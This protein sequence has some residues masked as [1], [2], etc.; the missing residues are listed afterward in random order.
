MRTLRFAGDVLLAILGF[1]IF[2][3]GA[4][5][6]L[7]T[8]PSRRTPSDATAAVL[9]IGAGLCV[10]GLAIWLARRN[11]NLAAESTNSIARGPGHG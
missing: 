2:A 11:R 1:V 7:G 8:T 4:G 5:Y 6:L 9:G 10:F 3:L